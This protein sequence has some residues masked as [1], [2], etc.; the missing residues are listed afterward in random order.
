VIT[1]WVITTPRRRRQF[2]ILIDTFLTNPVN[3]SDDMPVTSLER[4]RSMTNEQRLDRLERIGKLFVKAGFRVRQQ[5]QEHDDKINI[6][7]NFQIQ[8]EERFAKLAESQAAT[9]RRL[10]SLIDIIREGRNGNASSSS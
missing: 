3:P 5:V 4:H 9:R 6:V 1:I 10:D 8:N 2:E 7:T